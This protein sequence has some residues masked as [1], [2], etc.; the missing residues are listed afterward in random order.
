MH[1]RSSNLTVADVMQVVVKT[2]HST[3]TLPDL[4]EEFLRSGVS[5]FP[6]VDDNKLVGVVSRSDVIRQLCNERDIA[7]RVSDF[8]FDETHFYEVKMSSFKDIADRVG[9]RIE[10]LE[11]KDVMTKNPFTTRLDQ[12]LAEVAKRFID[13]K[14]HRMPVTDMGTLV[15][16]VTTTD[17]MRLIAEKRI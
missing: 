13:H 1:E 7:E 4:E 3:M 16:I 10:G 8:H 14:I 17:L 2:V 11:V 5:G 9:E 15:G 12:T 6:V